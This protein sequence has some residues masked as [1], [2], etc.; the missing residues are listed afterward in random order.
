MIS[1]R[2]PACGKVIGFDEADGGA[3]VACPH[4]RQS[5]FV[6]VVARPVAVE[7]APPLAKAPVAPPV[8]ASLPQ[9]PSLPDEI[10]LADDPDLAP[11]PEHFDEVLPA[12]EPAPPPEAAPEPAPSPEPEPPPPDPIP[13]LELDPP[14]PAPPGGDEPIGTPAVVK[15][16]D[17]APSLPAA[18]S[19][20]ESLPPPEK[21]PDRPTDVLEEVKDEAEDKGRFD[22]KE[23]AKEEEEEDE[24]DRRPRPRSRKKGP[25]Y[26]KPY[27]A[28][29]ARAPEGLTRNRIM[30]GVGV[31][32]GGM[33]LLGTL[34]HHVAGSETAWHKAVC[35]GDVFALVLFGAGLF[36]LIR[37]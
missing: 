1:V 31:G 21:K 13:Y 10:R 6:P 36:Y 20:N 11:I 18:V 32:L 34:M 29:A 12:D 7:S 14:R 37:G 4:C 35:C 26:R 3:L 2:C 28:Q 16:T 19:L 30:G 33:I 24:E 15:P 27:Y 5:F 17:V 9:E 23:Q 25:D 8:V 22:E